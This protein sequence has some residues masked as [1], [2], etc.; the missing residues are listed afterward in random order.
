MNNNNNIKKLYLES[1]FHT[2]QDTIEGKRKEKE[3]KIISLII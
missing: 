3:D 2:T 1:T